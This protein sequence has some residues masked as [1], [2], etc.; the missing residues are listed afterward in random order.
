MWRALEANGGRGP[1][2]GLALKGVNLTL[3]GCL[4]RDFP[5]VWIRHSKKRNP[6]KKSATSIPNRALADYGAARPT[7]MARKSHIAHYILHLAIYM[8]HVA[9]F[10]LHVVLR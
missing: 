4:H 1:R 7:A 2:E 9:G 3:R 5:S 10:M 6:L 8:L